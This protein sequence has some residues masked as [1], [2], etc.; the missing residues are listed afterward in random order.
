MPEVTAADLKC[1]SGIYNSSRGI[2]DVLVGKN[3]ALPLTKAISNGDIST[4][5]SLLADPHWTEVAL[6]SEHY[7]MEEYHSSEG[8][9]HERRVCGR[10]TSTLEIMLR[11]AITTGSGTAVTT[12]LD[13]GAQHE[14]KTSKLIWR[15][16]IKMAMGKGRESAFQ[17]LGHADPSVATFNIGHSAMPQYTLNM[18]ISSLNY[19]LVTVILQLIAKQDAEDPSHKPGGRFRPGTFF[20][21]AM[22]GIRMTELMLEYEVPMTGALHGAAVRGNL[23]VIRL[24]VK[25]GADV[26][27]PLS[28]E[29]AYSRKTA[30]LPSWTPMHC[31]AARDEEE[32]VKLLESLGGSNDTLDCRGKT[33]RQVQQEDCIFSGRKKI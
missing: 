13:F 29:V 26:N 1:P 9:Q 2:Y 8:N 25:R 15:E 5:R 24:L 32:A 27:E 33:P 4:L 14:V 11:T 22:M 3:I 31:A 6:R 23:D 10:Y 17:A 21:A 20:V 7:I 12:V 28:K 19:E 16:T 30:C 18:A